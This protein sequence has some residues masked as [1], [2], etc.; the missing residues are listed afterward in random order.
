MSVPDTILLEFLNT[1]G[2]PVRLIDLG[3]QFLDQMRVPP[4][5]FSAPFQIKIEKKAS[6]AGNDYYDYYQN[7]V[8]LPEGL[9]TFLKV[10]GS[11]IPMGKVH[12]SKNGFPT[13][14]GIAHVL[15]GSVIYK[16]TAYL[17]E[18]K[19]PFW[20]KVIAHKLP[21]TEGNIKKAQMAPRG[22]QINF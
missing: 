3:V 11:I 14:E 9:N 6:K 16:V 19:G 12:P 7:A 5:R 20:V 2:E 17:T 8:P 18:G 4:S 13:R 10:E 22:G 21:N 1:N 15:I